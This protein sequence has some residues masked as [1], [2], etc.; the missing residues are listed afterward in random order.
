VFD[1]IATI[2]AS[3]YD[4]SHSYG[5]AIILLTLGVMVLLTPLT[6]KGTRS[7]MAMQRL[8]PEMKRLQQKHKGDRQKLNEEMMK[9]Y[10]ENN[11][12]PLGGCLPLLLQLPVFIVLY[13]VVSG[14]TSRGEGG[15]FDPK[16]VS[17]D[18]DLYKA[19]H[20]SKEMVSFGIDLSR[21]ASQA[22]ADSFV[23]GLPYLVLIAL[24]AATGWYQ[25]RQMTAR[26]TAMGGPPLD[27]AQAQQ[28][29]IM[30][31]M[32]VILPVFSW[33]IPAG[34]VLYF[35][36]SNLYR[37]AQQAYIQV[38]YFRDD[39]GSPTDATAPRSRRASGAQEADAPP[40]TSSNPRAG[41]NPSRPRKKKKKR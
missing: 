5:W 38:T 28:Q 9:F 16:Y 34:V 30:K 10:K 2:L 8:Q 14:I 1:L 37:V 35:L 27:P 12:N 19:L 24:V 23:D 17:H 6:L 29:A 13:R 25:Q 39:G 22:L 26:R 41:Q 20:E 3:L 18:S 15:F 40:A 11:I 4:F 36:V 7:M 31:W 33:A 21:S 32:W